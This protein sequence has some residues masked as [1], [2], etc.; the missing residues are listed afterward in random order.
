MPL[1]AVVRP[2][3]D[4]SAHRSHRP[5]CEEGLFHRIVHRDGSMRNRLSNG[6]LARCGGIQRGTAA[7]PRWPGAHFIYRPFRVSGRA[8]EPG[9]TAPDSLALLL[10]GGVGQSCRLVGHSVHPRAKEP[11]GVGPHRPRTHLPVKPSAPI[12]NEATHARAV[13]LSSSRCKRAR[14]LR[15][16]RESEP[17]HRRTHPHCRRRAAPGR[18]VTDTHRGQP[19]FSQARCLRRSQGSPVSMERG[20]TALVQRRA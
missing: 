5:L 9:R 3:G 4:D 8:K 17:P 10:P 12:S 6:P 14:R 18:P 7:K 20:S 11:R 19:R 1:I 15:L 16:R 2:V 13:T